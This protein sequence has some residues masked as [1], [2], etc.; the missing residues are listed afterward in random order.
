MDARLIVRP[1]KISIHNF[2]QTVESGDTAA[3]DEGALVVGGGELRYY[4]TL[5]CRGMDEAVIIDHD[6]H[7]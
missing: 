7:M 2:L 4:H 6:A 1:F 3:F 5:L